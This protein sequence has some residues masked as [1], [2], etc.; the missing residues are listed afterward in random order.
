MPA[1]DTDRGAASYSGP[2]LVDVRVAQGE[3]SH[4][5]NVNS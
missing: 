1:T 3:C 5:L 4:R 2:E